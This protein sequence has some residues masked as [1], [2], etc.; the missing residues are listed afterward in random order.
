MQNKKIIYGDRSQTDIPIQN[1]LTFDLPPWVGDRYYTNIFTKR[2]R[3]FLKSLIPFK[4]ILL[5]NI[6]IHKK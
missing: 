6:T 4:N 3:P 1:Y 5:W 2:F